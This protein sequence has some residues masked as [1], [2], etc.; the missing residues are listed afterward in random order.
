MTVV[1]YSLLLF[2]LKCSRTWKNKSEVIQLEEFTRPKLPSWAFPIINCSLNLFLMNMRHGGRL[3]QLAHIIPH[4]VIIVYLSGDEMWVIWWCPFGVT[5]LRVS[6]T[7]SH[8]FRK[9]NIYLSKICVSVNN[10]NLKYKVISSAT[11]RY[12]PP[13]PVS[14]F[15]YSIA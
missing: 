11:E 9:D 6:I 3:L 5:S 10:L 12:S 13:L 7:F 1:L 2:F 15:E 4:I 8:Q 14:H